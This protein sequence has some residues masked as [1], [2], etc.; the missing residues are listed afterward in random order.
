MATYAFTQNPEID[1]NP[2]FT[3]N[4]TPW[5]IHQLLMPQVIRSESDRVPVNYGMLDS[6]VRW[7]KITKIIKTA[8]AKQ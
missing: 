2:E 4:S 3:E 6:F 1:R 8:E 7:Q 5:Y